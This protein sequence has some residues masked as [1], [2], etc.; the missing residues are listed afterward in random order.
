MARPKQGQKRPFAVEDVGKIREMLYEDRKTLRDMALLEVALSTMLRAVDLL[1]LRVKDICDH[2]GQ[3]TNE[4]TITQQ[5]TQ[6]PV[7]CT[8]SE[9]AMTALAV[10][11]AS[12]RKGLDDYVFTHQNPCV[13]R[14]ISRLSWSQIVKKWANNLGLDPR[15]YSTHSMRRT[16]AAHIYK[17]TKDLESVR[18]LLGHTSLAATG[19]YLGVDLEEALKQGKKWQM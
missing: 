8:L 19:R 16:R 2:R 6:T 10:Y 4:F 9:R 11:I 18:I 5:K 7:T 3:L 17:A 15:Q 14:K 1:N 13:N 12:Y